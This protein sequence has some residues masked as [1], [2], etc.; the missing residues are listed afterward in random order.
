MINNSKVGDRCKIPFGDLCN[1]YDCEV[2]EGSFIGPFVEIQKGAKIG[3]NCRIQ[4]HSFI[5]S[6]VV[7]EDNVFIGHGVIFCNDL[8]PK[9]GEKWEMKH[10]LVKT[11][12][13]IGNNATILPVEVGSN[14]LIGAG[15]VVTQDIPDNATVKGN[16]AK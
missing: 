10:T 6:G 11:G 9:I 5:C 13:S 12:A 4:S 8:Y 7:I 2:G 14:A 1:I 3:K 15:S 16:P